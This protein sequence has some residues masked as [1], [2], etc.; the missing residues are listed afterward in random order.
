MNTQKLITKSLDEIAPS[1][2]F[3]PKSVL[4]G[5]CEIGESTLDRYRDDLVEIQ[6]RKFEWLFYGGGYT[7]DSAECIHQYAQLIKIMRVAITKQNIK[8][9][10]EEF[11]RE[12]NR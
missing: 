1:V 6:P 4:A 3:F 2:W 10:M 5:L 9:H 12:K 8:Q 7:R 11:W